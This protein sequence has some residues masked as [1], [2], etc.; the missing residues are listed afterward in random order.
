MRRQILI[1]TLAVALVTLLIGI[2]STALIRRELLRRSQAEIERQATAT[3]AIIDQ[4]LTV[5][6]R[7]GRTS[8][9]ARTIGQLRLLGGHDHVEVAAVTPAGPEPLGDSTLLLDS[10]SAAEATG[11]ATTSVEIEGEPVLATFRR[12]S[13]GD[14]TWVVAIGRTEPLLVAGLFTRPLMVGAVVGAMVALG[15]A[16]W[17]SRRIGRR[18]DL[19]TEV[20]ADLAAGDFSARAATEGDDEIAELGRG[21]NTM[22]E[23]L[24]RLRAREREFL[25]SVGHDLRTPLTTIRGYV[26]GLDEGAVATDDVPRIAGVLRTQTD[27]LTRLVDDLAQLA[28]LEA[29]EFALRPEPVALR[30]HLEETAAAVVPL[31]A[32]SDVRFTISLEDVGIAEIDPD[33]VGQIVANL[34]DNALRWTPGGGEVKLRL[35]AGTGVVHIVVGD[36][37]PG[38]EPSDL[39]HIFDRSFM[40]SR[41]PVRQ[42][43]SGLGL[44]IVRQLAEAMGGTAAATSVL[45]HGTDVTVTLPWQHPVTTP[46]RLPGSPP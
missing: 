31:A 5:A 12:V 8:G 41:Q 38:I 40:A 6:V 9:V 3:A 16:L 7:E 2:G 42:H 27:R 35:S 18:I 39:P 28:R 1:G 30:A 45:G 37:G 21:F 23:Q 44:A 19:L 29:R 15:M 17:M 32:D 33:R 43:G 14:R 24:V 25:M 20:S 36:T 26:E 22:A 4:Q 13:V 34:L 10:M 11:E 46:D